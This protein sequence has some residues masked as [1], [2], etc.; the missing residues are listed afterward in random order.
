MSVESNGN[1]CVM[2]TSPSATVNSQKRLDDFFTHLHLV[3]C[4]K[5]M[6]FSSTRATSGLSDCHCWKWIALLSQIW[7]T[8][9]GA[10]LRARVVPPRRSKTQTKMSIDLIIIPQPTFMKVCIH[11]PSIRSSSKKI[12]PVLMS[13][14]ANS[15]LDSLIVLIPF[16]EES[17]CWD[18]PQKWSFYG[19]STWFLYQR[20]IFAECPL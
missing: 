4:G 3:S 16:W 1:R 11:V 15:W 10:K 20:D 17:L 14:V 18:T 5:C 12:A 19:R 13:V 8:V 9:V 7:K 2:V 6:L